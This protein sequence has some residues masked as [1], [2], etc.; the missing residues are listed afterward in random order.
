MR[1][2]G[3]NGNGLPGV[4]DAHAESDRFRGLIGLPLYAS[5]TIARIQD[6]STNETENEMGYLTESVR[7]HTQIRNP[8]VHVCRVVVDACEE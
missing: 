2:A 4:E 5:K 3:R 7:E 8:V 1:R 6:G